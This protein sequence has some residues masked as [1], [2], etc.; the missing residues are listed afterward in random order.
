MSHKLKINYWKHFCFPLNCTLWRTLGFSFVLILQSCSFFSKSDEAKNGGVPQWVSNP[1]YDESNSS[2]AGEGCPRNYLCAVGSGKNREES[3]LVATT[4]LAKFFRSEVKGSFEH[5]VS[6]DSQSGRVAEEDWSQDHIQESTEM[7]LEGATV[8]KVFEKSTGEYFTLVGIDKMRLAKLIQ[9]D[10]NII[11]DNIKELLIDPNLLKL[12]RVRS[13]MK[14]REVFE[15][16]YVFLTQ[17][18][19]PSVISADAFSA[20]FTREKNKIVLSVEFLKKSSGANFEKLSQRI[21][22]SLKQEFQQR[23]FLIVSSGEA[24]LKL[25]LEL[26]LLQLPIQVDGFVKSQLYLKGKFS[27]EKT[28]GLAELVID[29]STTARS[30]ELLLEKVE[31]MFHDELKKK[32]D[33]QYL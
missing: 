26:D 5:S 30:K 14:D 1:Q 3:R 16:Q 25:D 11:D 19:Y 24:N 18:N 7:V 17:K 8:L 15:R 13:F 6:V 20:L 9:E 31:L 12:S 33:D 2:S 28:L 4:Q 23:G 29:F 27:P 10:L 21:L 22:N 32:L